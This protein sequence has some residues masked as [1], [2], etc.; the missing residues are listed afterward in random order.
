MQ[1]APSEEGKV[2]ALLLLIHLLIMFKLI[3]R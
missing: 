2:A 1:L 3:C